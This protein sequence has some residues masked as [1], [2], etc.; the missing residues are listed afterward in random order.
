[1][2][3][4][5]IRVDAGDGKEPALSAHNVDRRGQLVTTESAKGENKMWFYHVG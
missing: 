5:V 3:F 4:A 1:M 2:A